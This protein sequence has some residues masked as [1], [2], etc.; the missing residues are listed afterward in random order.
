MKHVKIKVFQNDVFQKYFK[1]IFKMK[2]FNFEIFCTTNK[3]SDSEQ[4]L[5]FHQSFKQTLKKCGAIEIL[6]F[7]VII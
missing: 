5:D 6:F 7:F 4:L 1:I 2:D 3:R